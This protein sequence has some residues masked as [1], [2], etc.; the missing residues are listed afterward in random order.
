MSN[1]CIELHDS[2][3]RALR[4]ARGEVQLELD[5]YVHMS[6]GRPGI[7]AG[8]G[9]T[10]PIRMTLSSATLV[11]DFEGDG[12]WITDGTIRV[13]STVLDN[14]CP[15]TFDVTDEIQIRFVGHEGSLTVTGTRLQV[16]PV[17]AATFVEAVPGSAD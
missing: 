8:T 4:E 9:W 7:D 13:G 2:K 3:V 11:R 15:V 5:A 17:G 1:Q 6:E 12:L 10:V 16:E 14:E